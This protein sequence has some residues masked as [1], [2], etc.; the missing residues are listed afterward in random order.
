MRPRSPLPKGVVE[1]RVCATWIDRVLSSPHV[2]RSGSSTSRCHGCRA[3][4]SAAPIPNGPPL[5]SKNRVF[6]VAAQLDSPGQHLLT[7]LSPGRLRGDEDLAQ[8]ADHALN[9]NA[10]D[11]GALLETIYGAEAAETFEQVWIAHGTALFNYARGV[12]D[13]DATMKSEARGQLDTYVSELSEYPTSRPPA[14]RQKVVA[15]EIAMH[16]DH[17]LRR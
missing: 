9:G 12:A 14:I 10:T 11:I 3:T 15:K 7:S 8:T 2:I 1:W 17:L 6:R 4:D 5:L 16:V 13:E